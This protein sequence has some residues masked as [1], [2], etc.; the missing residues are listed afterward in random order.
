[1]ENL[2]KDKEFEGKYNEMSYIMFEHILAGAIDESQSLL[3][4]LIE[5]ELEYVK[6]EIMFIE[7]F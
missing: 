1:M 6:N 2:Y 5:Q 7:N 4:K 3:K